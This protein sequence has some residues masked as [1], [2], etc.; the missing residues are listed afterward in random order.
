M[1]DLRRGLEAQGEGF[2]F[3]GD[4]RGGREGGREG[5]LRNWDAEKG[6]KADKRTSDA[7]APSDMKKELFAAVSV[8]AMGLH[9]TNRQEGWEGGREEG[10]EEGRVEIERTRDADAPSERK[11]LL[12][13]VWVP[14][15]F[16][17]AGLSL[18]RVSA[19]DS[20]LIPFSSVLPSTG[21]ISCGGK[22]GGRQGGRVR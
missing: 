19:V 8:R 7:D 15:G 10:R 17:K 13:A 3:R 1:T 16:T 21:I 22:E 5:G 2:L 4:L 12:A 20:P 11:E 18:A 14:W 9:K 6:K